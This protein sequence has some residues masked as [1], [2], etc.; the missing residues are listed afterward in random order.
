MNLA[1]SIEKY[2]TT[3]EVA[4]RYRTAPSTIRYWRHINY[5]P[6][7]VRRG[8]RVLYDPKKLDAWD[9]EQAGGAA[10]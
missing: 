1:E 2:L 8:R 10:A 5:I 7:G 3:E 4:K 9:A 6:S